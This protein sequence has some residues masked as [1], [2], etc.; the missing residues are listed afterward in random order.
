MGVVNGKG[1]KKYE[2]RH[3]DVLRKANYEV[4]VG[5]FLS[6]VFIARIL[7]FKGS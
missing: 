2:K 3:R 6:P 4:L 1:K 7:S 5:D